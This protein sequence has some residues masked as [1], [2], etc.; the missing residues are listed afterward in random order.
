MA[1]DEFQQLM[2]AGL[3]AWSSLYILRWRVPKWNPILIWVETLVLLGLG[4]MGHYSLQTYDENVWVGGWSD[5]LDIV[6][7]LFAFAGYYGFTRV[8]AGRDVIPDRVR[9]WRSIWQTMIGQK[10]DE[11]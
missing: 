6:I 9:N 3:I 2:V 8:L 7:G 4:Y 11:N 10:T 1:H 5:W